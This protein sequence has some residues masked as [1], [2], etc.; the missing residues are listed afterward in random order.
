VSAAQWVSICAF[1]DLTPDRGAA[2][3]VNGAQVA[4]FRLA[5][6]SL[7]AVSHKDPYSGANIMARGLV[8]TRGDEPTVASPMLKQVFS[9]VSGVALDDPD[10]RL[11]VWPVRLIDGTVEVGPPPS[12]GDE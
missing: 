1:D 3:L 6:D 8:G 7:H 11:G 10:V 2:A 12:E 9:L 5:D 4:V